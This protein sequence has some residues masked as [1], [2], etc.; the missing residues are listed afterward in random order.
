M[1]RHVCECGSNVQNTRRSIMMH[2]QTQK[3]ARWAAANQAAAI[4]AYAIQNANILRPAVPSPEEVA[5]T[6]LAERDL[7][8]VVYARRCQWAVRRIEAAYLAWR[9]RPVDSWEY[10]LALAN[11]EGRPA[12]EAPWANDL[13]DCSA[14]VYDESD[15]EGSEGSVGGDDSNDSDDTTTQDAAR[16]P[17]PVLGRM[18]Q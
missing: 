4:R 3:H 16:I 13:P 15:D 10:Q 5:A 17:A 8:N 6:K 2:E 7:N 11:Y 9:Y 12:P 18:D 14:F 1:S